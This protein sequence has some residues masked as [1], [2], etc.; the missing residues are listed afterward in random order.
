MTLL[1]DSYTKA[2]SEHEERISIIT[3]EIKDWDVK[4]VN[5]ISTDDFQVPENEKT[6]S[7]YEAIKRLKLKS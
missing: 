3:K 1:I 5:Q 4:I 6:K 2:N 7:F